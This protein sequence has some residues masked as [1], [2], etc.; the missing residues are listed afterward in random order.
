[1]AEVVCS[2][3]QSLDGYV[4]YTAPHDLLERDFGEG[5][6]ASR[7]KRWGDGGRRSQPDAESHRDG[8][9]EENWNC[10]HPVVLGQGMPYFAGP[11][12]PPPL[13]EYDRVDEGVLRLT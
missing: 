10:Q 6:Q 3:T 8:L 9:I 4:D 13:A 5:V 12:P 2:M 1:M 11:P 7:P